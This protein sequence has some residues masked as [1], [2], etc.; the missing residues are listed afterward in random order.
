M[1][2]NTFLIKGNS[3]TC[4]FSMTCMPLGQIHK[5]AF[6]YLILLSVRKNSPMFNSSKKA[7]PVI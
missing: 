1:E 5:V 3:D 6:Y 4:K 2:V 7:A